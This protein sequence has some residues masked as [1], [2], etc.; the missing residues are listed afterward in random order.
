MDNASEHI[1]A[2]KMKNDVERIFSHTLTV[3][4]SY[5]ILELL[6]LSKRGTA[7]TCTKGQFFT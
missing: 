6:Q 7:Q 4:M 1:K 2:I 5:A 3:K